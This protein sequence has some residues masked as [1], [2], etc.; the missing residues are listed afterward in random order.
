MK[1]LSTHAFREGKSGWCAGDGYIVWRDKDLVGMAWWGELNPTIV[2]ET[3]SLLRA[4]TVAIGRPIV[5]VTDSR[6]ITRVH[7]SAFA[8]MLEAMRN[9]SAFFITHLSRQI[10]VIAPSAEE[11]TLLGLVGLSG[12]PWPVAMVT[13]RAG[14]VAALEPRA[15]ELLLEVERLVDEASSA[16]ALLLELAAYLQAHLLDANLEGAALHLRLTPR[17]L[18]RRLSELGR[19]FR[20]EITVARVTAARP[21]IEASDLKLETIAS[22]VGFASSSN[23]ASAFRRHCGVTPQSLRR[24]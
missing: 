9:D 17:S 22:R 1:R 20:D 3:T 11:A 12:F 2:D 6:R 15:D 5:L 4:S 21:L 13:D 18:Q 7:P 23:L 8:T 14:A 24:R 19:S 10:A 16:P